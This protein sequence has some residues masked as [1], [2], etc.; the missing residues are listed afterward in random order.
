V[1]TIKRY[2][3]W[4]VFISVEKG[5]TKFSLYSGCPAGRFGGNCQNICLCAVNTTCD[6]VTGC[7]KCVAKGLNGGACDIDINECNNTTICGQH[8]TCNN[9]IGSYSCGCETGFKMGTYLCEGTI[10]DSFHSSVNTLQN[11]IQKRSYTFPF[12]YSNTA[13]I[14]LNDE[15]CKMHKF[16]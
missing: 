11:N 8:A 14:L 7:S 9:L 3:K 2:V 1:H 13:I 6:P 5:N 12:L 16:I 10:I 4:Y 15:I